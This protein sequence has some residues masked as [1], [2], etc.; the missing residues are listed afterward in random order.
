MHISTSPIIVGRGP[1]AQFRLDDPSV[2]SSHMEIVRRGNQIIVKDLNSTNGVYLNGVK[3]DREAAVTEGDVISLGSLR[4]SVVDNSLVIAPEEIPRT[5]I[6]ASSPNSTF[7]SSPPNPR[8]Q[9]DM[10]SNSG[11]FATQPLPKI[12]DEKQSR[13]G[14]GFAIAGLVLGIVAFLILPVIC[15]PLGIIFG[16]ISWSK[17]NRT[18]MAATIVSI[19]GLVIGMI[20]GAIVWSSTI[21]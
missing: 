14:Q 20:L 11:A 6:S 13:P 1:H 5:I 7:D 21:Y 17:G 15:G 18:G 12:S 19:C 3:V 16:A 9:H 4:L 8:P 10:A 2:S